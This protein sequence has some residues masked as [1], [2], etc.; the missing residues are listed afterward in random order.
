MATSF[1]FI[2]KEDQTNPTQPLK[3]DKI[4]RFPPQL[5]LISQQYYPKLN[6]CTH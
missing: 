5:N 2:P 1:I 3:V 4:K 6:F